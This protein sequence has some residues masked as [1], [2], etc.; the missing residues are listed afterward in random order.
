MSFDRLH[1]GRVYN[2]RYKVVKGKMSFGR[3]HQGRL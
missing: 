3:L 2:V 1:Q